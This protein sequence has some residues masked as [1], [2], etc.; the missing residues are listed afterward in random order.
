MEGFECSVKTYGSRTGPV[1]CAGSGPGVL[2]IHEIPGLH[3][4]VV[5]FGRELVDAGF[6]VWMPEVFG[7]AEKPAGLGYAVKEIVKACLSKEFATW[8]TGRTSPITDDLRVLARELAEHTSGSVGAIG[9]CL[10]G[11][12]ALAM[13][14]DP[15]VTAPVLSQPSLPFAVFPW[16]KRDLGIDASTLCA[17]QKRVDAGACVLGLRYRGDRSVPDE[18]FERLRDELGDGFEAVEIEGSKHSVLTTHR[19]EASV[20]RTIAFLQKH[21]GAAWT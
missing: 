7:V 5:Q 17:V 3:P 14:V 10:T 12:F 13:M 1:W 16:Q 15:W 4:F 19:H 6:T 2:V 21:T 11:G 20:Q 8:R 9:M 18:R